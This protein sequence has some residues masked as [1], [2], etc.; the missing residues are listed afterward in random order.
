MPTMS[1][2][3]PRTRITGDRKAP[4]HVARIVACLL[5]ILAISTVMRCSMVRRPS[6][7]RSSPGRVSILVPEG[8]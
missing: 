4:Y 2:R 3:N 8:D 6:F 1:I 7:I 5:A